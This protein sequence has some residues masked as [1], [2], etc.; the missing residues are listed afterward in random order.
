[1]IHQTTKFRVIQTEQKSA[2][3]NM[4]IDDALLTSYNK[5]DLAI[6]RLYTWDK[7]LTIGIS[8]DFS[9]YSFINEYNGNFA[10]RIT[11]GGI[12]F[13]GHDL[14]YSL[15][16]PTQ[17]FQGLSIKQSYEIIC[18]FILNFYKDLGLDAKYAKDDLNVK[19]SKSEYCQVGFEAYDILVNGIKIGGNAQRRTKKAIF[20]HGSIP[21]LSPNKDKIENKFGASLENMN[22]NITFEEA[23][24]RLI[25]SFEKSFNVDLEYSQLTKIENE[26]KDLLL[27]DK[28][29]YA[30][31]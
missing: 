30:N 25:N 24:K 14:S 21:V 17:F 23:K 12:L 27:K 31:N 26:K 6:L 5:N 19:L 22:I 13:H 16:I 28:Y 3:E 8:Q 11:G 15:I 9:E 1:M 10:K 7:S 2:N 20:Q 29:D 4:A 18:S